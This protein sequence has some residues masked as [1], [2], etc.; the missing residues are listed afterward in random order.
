VLKQQPIAQASRKAPEFP[1]F[2]PAM[3]LI[4]EGSEFIAANE[5]PDPANAI[6]LE[7]NKAMASRFGTQILS[8]T[9]P[10][11]ADD[12]ASMATAS[13]GTQARF[14]IDVRTLNWS[15]QHFPTNWDKYL[16]MYT[17]KL[18]LIDLQSNLVVAEG[19]C[20][21]LRESEA[22]APGLGD[23]V[24]NGQR[25]GRFEASAQWSGTKMRGVA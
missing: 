11:R 4:S 6:A 15:L 3:A 17:A 12:P 25:W 1:I 18:R 14:L 23:L 20:K 13:A 21:R 16:L 9:T 5:V 2:T 7:F 8:T 19:F 10:M 22:T 24:D